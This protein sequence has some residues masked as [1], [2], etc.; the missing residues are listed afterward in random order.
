MRKGQV[1]SYDLVI[2]SIIFVLAMAVLAFFWWSVRTNMSED[3]EAIIRESFK[4]SDMLMSPGIPQN[5]S[6]LVNLSNQSTWS[7]VQGIGLAESW[8]NSS[9]SVDKVYKLINMS[10]VNSSLVQNKLRSRYN[11]YLQFVFL[12][13][14]NNSVEQPVLM[15]QTAIVAGNLYNL[16]TVQAIARDDRIAVYNNSIVIM[17]L[18]LWSNS[19]LD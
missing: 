14:S 17:R 1:W 6:M 16:T 12:N 18:Y 5:W 4:V 9:L 7:N 13:T 8:T 10:S 15:N 19:S 3:K 2:A 11:F